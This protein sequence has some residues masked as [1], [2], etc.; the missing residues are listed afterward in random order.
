[1]LL[2]SSKISQVPGGEYDK[3]R[4]PNMC[5][6]L[7][8]PFFPKKFWQH[9]RNEKLQAL[10]IKLFDWAKENETRYEPQ[11]LYKPTFLELWGAEFCPF[12]PLTNSLPTIALKARISFW[13]INSVMVD[14]GK[15]ENL[16]TQMHRFDKLVH[17]YTEKSMVRFIM[18]TTFLHD[19]YNHFLWTLCFMLSLWKD[20]QC[21]T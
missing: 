15:C 9:I 4:L 1:M 7:V 12:C 2:N 8:Y 21:L 13:W 18:K 20:L 6:K 14:F 17:N 5:L 19:K 3:D 16:T 10:I 11:F